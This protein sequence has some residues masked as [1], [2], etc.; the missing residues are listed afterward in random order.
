MFSAKTAKSLRHVNAGELR[1]RPLLGTVYCEKLAEQLIPAATKQLNNITFHPANPDHMRW[2]NRI[3]P[4]AAV[5]LLPPEIC[6]EDDTADWCKEKML[7]PVLA[8]VRVWLEQL[9]T[10]SNKG[11]LVSPSGAEARPDGLAYS[12]TLCHGKRDKP[13]ISY[14]FKTHN[15]L[16]PS[17]F[18]M[19]QQDLPSDLGP[20]YARAIRFPHILLGKTSI[21]HNIVLLLQVRPFDLWMMCL[22]MCIF[23][24]IWGHLEKYNINRAMLMSYKSTIFFYRKLKDSII[25]ISKTHDVSSSDTVSTLFAFLLHANLA[26][27]NQSEPEIL[28]AL[29]V[30][31]PD[32]RWWDSTCYDQG[33]FYRLL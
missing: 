2:W 19:I 4:S 25:Y 16:A 7:R 9:V 20:E 11:Y 32:T 28:N 30:P 22:F 21:N 26:Q 1:K 31:I 24:Q 15:A 27:K 3:D 33:V 12:G 23:R 6:S 17:Q 18:S 10:H 14:D 5:T 13:Y 8:F 29:A